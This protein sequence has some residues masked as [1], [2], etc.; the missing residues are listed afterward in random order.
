MHHHRR[1]LRL[2]LPIATAALL[3]F[4]VAEWLVERR[5]GSA[6]RL[7]LD[8]ALPVTAAALLAFA[9]AASLRL[10]DRLE[11]RNR[12]L[13][14][15]HEATLDLHGELTLGAVLQ[16][17]VD[18]ACGLLDARY[19]AVSV[20]DA[21]GAIREFVTSGVSDELRAAIGDPPRGRGLLGIVLRDGQRLRLSD[22]GADPR[23]A[24]FPPHH[25]RMTSLLAVPIACRKSGFR[26]NLYVADKRSAAEFSAADEETLA[27]FADAAAAAIDTADLHQR[28]RF[29][30]V[31]EDR[32]RIAFELHDGMAQVLAYV[33]AKSQAAVEHL[34]HGRADEV[35]QQLEQLAAGARELY[36]DVREVILA[37][38]TRL[39][40][41]RSFG[42][43]LGE[44][45]ASWR[46]RYRVPVTLAIDDGVEPAPAV[47]LQVLRIVQEALSNVR[48][49]AGASRATV[50][51]GRDGDG[52]LAIEVADDGRGFDPAAPAP[53]GS[54]R[55]GL[56]MMRERAES[57]GGRLEV[58]TAPGGG[59]RLRLEVPSGLEFG[60]SPR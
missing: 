22:V 28:L 47:A 46:E 8:L 7:V 37:L 39:T 19:G 4:G 49:H 36:G 48:K 12:E 10:L 27:R 20:V 54:P 43:T 23:A 42:A 52:R 14:A 60:A 6:G 24:G 11:R 55:F 9:C 30:A 58:A 50:T 56:L 18:R 13:S 35:E 40:P 51:V 1:T 25:P 45:I 16:R 41:E 57:V 53:A 34:R 5:L 26:G 3:L 15:L 33:N 44:F 32:T 2:L 38:N 17:T 21:E 59:T 31:S 29:L